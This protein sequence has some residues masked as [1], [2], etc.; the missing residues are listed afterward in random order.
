[1]PT[2]TS[3]GPPYLTRRSPNDFACVN[4]VH[5]PLEINRRAQ[6]MRHSVCGTLLL[7]EGSNVA[8]VRDGPNEFSTR[9]SYM[10]LRFGGG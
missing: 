9:V 1:M 3:V 5:M 2:Y 8:L 7:P 6:A 10:R 4:V